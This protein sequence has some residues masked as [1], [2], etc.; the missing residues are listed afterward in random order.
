[1]ILKE[2]PASVRPRERLLYYGR[3]TLTDRELLALLL[4]TG[5][6]DKT[7]LGL[8]DEL[9]I[10]F[11][12]GLSD[13]TCEELSEVPGIG[14]AKACSVIAGLELGKR[15]AA[16]PVRREALTDPGQA[17]AFFESRLSRLHQ[18][19]FLV[20]LVDA[21]GQ[22]IGLEE[23]ARGDVTGAVT[24]PRETFRTAVKRGAFAVILAHNHPSG[25][26]TPSG[27]DLALTR[28]L[29]EAGKLLGIRVVDHII[30]GEGRYISLKQE[31][32]LKEDS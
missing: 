14:T 23:V 2:M 19:R 26:P 21:K 3:E 30:I 5:T 15:L 10:R 4:G 12:E 27:A 29:C 8:A 16:R 6:R 11:P 32:C 9:L 20:A 1:M 13:L 24:G 31:G 18:E 28:Q 22:V 17:A 7:A 25:D